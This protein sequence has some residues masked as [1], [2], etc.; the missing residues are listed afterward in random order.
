M[1]KKAYAVMPVGSGWA[2]PA[3][4]M[5]LSRWG[6]KRSLKWAAL[7]ANWW[8]AGPASSVRA[9][10]PTAFSPRNLFTAYACTARC[11]GGMRRDKRPG[12]LQATRHGLAGGAGRVARCS[13][14][15]NRSTTGWSPEA[16]DSDSIW[17]ASSGFGDQRRDDGGSVAKGEWASGSTA[18]RARWD[19]G[20]TELA[21]GWGNRSAWVAVPCVGVADGKGRSV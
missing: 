6:G 8:A 1:R 16:G 17:A 15:A 12:A 9:M 4:P 21:A 3:N 14:S 11:A 2:Q 7:A 5:Q 18:G 10:T 19:S 13:G 20:A